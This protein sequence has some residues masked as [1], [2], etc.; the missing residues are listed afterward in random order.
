MIRD[1]RRLALAALAATALAFPCALDA[2]GQAPPKGAAKKEAA[3]QPA[4]AQPADSGE[5]G[6]KQAPKRKKQDPLEAQR[7]IEAAA[8]LLEAGRADQAEQA[9]TAVINGGNLPPAIMAKA[10]LYRGIAYRQQKKPAQA[11]A[12]LTSALWLKGGLAEADRGDAMRQRT[13][14]YQEAGLGDNGEA[15]APAMPGPTGR[16]ATRTASASGVSD[17]APPANDGQAEAPAK[18]SG[19]WGIAN[20]FA[21]WFGG[22]SSAPPAPDRSPSTTASVEPPPP[23]H[24]PKSSS[25][26][27]NTEVRGTPA[28]TS[29]PAAATVVAARPEGRFRVQVGMTRSQS[30]AQSLAARI[31]REHAGVLATREPEIDEAVVGNMGSFYRVRIGPFATAQ[32]GQAA[33]AKMRG[34]GVDCLVVTQ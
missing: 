33:C 32:E 12:D 9:L 24:A 10:L 20:P 11:I 21:G 6:A 14:A 23:A 16:A 1:G 30:D 18:Q 28:A 26:T 29:A 5:E 31:K 15:I 4:A 19:G 17:N 13:S 8:K 7:S 2:A 22:G 25:W 3:Q 27:H 34:P